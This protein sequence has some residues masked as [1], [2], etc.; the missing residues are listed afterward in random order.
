MKGLKLI[1]PDWDDI[2]DANY[3]F[4][5]EKH[6]EGYLK[7]RYMHGARI[8]DLLGDEVIDGVLISIS[9]IKRDKMKKILG[10]GG[11]RN[12]LR[13][14]GKMQ[15]IGD[16]GAWQYRDKDA[17]PYRVDEVMDYYSR[18]GVDY[19]VT[20]DHIPFFGNPQERMELTFRNA[21]E[22]Y[23]LWRS[24]NYKFTLMASVQGIEVNHYV[25]FMDKLYNVGYRHF[26]IGGLAK[27]NTGFIK[28]LVSALTEY[29]RG[30]SD[31]E[32][33]H[34]LGVTRL[35]I[36]PML[37]ELLN[38]VNEVSFDS[39]AMLRMA[40][41]REVGNYLTTNGKAYTAIRVIGDNHD[42]LNALRLYDK[43]ALSLE[44]V[45]ATLRNYLTKV[46]QVH[47]LPYYEALLR[48]T[49]WKKCSC[50][51]C[52]TVGIDVVIFRGN[53]RNRRR[54]FHNVYVF[55]RL[56]ESGK[57][58]RFINVKVNHSI[59]GDEVASDELT[60]LLKKASRVLIITNC[61][62][63]KNVDWNDVLNLLRSR[64]LKVPSFDIELEDTYR[65]VLRQFMKPAS[66]MYGGSFRAIRNLAKAFRRLGKQVDV[67]VISARYGLISERE[68][69]LPYNATLKGLD[70][71]AIRN[72]S[73]RL[74]LEKKLMELVEKPY[75]VIIVALPR[76][77]A[78]AMGYA[79]RRLLNM[80]NA[81]L[82]LPK[83]II[84]DVKDIKAKVM[85]AGGLTARLKYIKRLTKALSSTGVTLDK[86]LL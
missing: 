36:I 16:C 54:G 24:G 60:T 52:R 71:D 63:E 76:E 64:G 14:P 19:G 50:A 42:V 8:W 37:S 5:N 39:S 85:L 79:L 78:I 45:I 83:S 73:K 18:L 61:T 34:F 30:R 41:T 26:A 47:Y 38:H 74:G 80:D 51:I 69:I 53:D 66:E 1:L 31:V 35:S 10:A 21:V 84:E 49:P 7:G 6:S 43:G 72:W 3:D 22:M 59:N 77:Y 70:I 56:L 9:A 67:Y 57:D 32:K 44:E 65:E 86:W 46:G 11:A 2:V 15:L 28:A 40:W 25:K 33:M 82:I 48:D 55:K 17:P 62:D 20:L 81:I 58:I 12:F 4:V 23:K 13:L 75:D 29:V 68:V 27:R